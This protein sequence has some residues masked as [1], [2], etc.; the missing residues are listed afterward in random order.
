MPILELA[1]GTKLPFVKPNLWDGAAVEKEMGWNRKE[2]AERMQSA[3]LQTAFSIFATL[4]RNGHD[5]TFTSCAEL[6]G[7][8]NI[9]AQ[10][11]DLARAD[12]SEGEESPDPQGSATPDAAETGA[13]PETHPS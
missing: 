4:R 12:E 1:D 5:V 3:S 11:G 9:L 7:I 13:T 10:P 8:V 2:Y 6:D